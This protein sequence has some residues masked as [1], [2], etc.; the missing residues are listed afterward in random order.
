M[1]H[2]I[3]VFSLLIATAAIIGGVYFSKNPAAYETCLVTARDILKKTFGFAINGVD[4]VKIMTYDEL[5]RYDGSPDG[6]GLYLAVYGKIYDVSKG[7]KHY[8]PGGGY[9]FFSGKDASR[10]YVTGEF[11]EKGLIDDLTGFTPQQAMEVKKWVEFYENTYTFVGKLNGRY[12]DENGNPTPEHA[13]VEDMI[14]EG[15]KLKEVDKA[16]KEKFPT[17]NS[18]W[19]QNEGGKVWCSTKSGGIARDWVGVPRKFFK[20]GS[21]QSRCACIRTTGP[22]SDQPDAKDHANRGDLDNPNI[23]EYE[24]CEPTSVSCALLL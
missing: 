16:E 21:T 24:D 14:A 17:C 7:A 10:A 9:E 2:K 15:I 18:E 12:Y 1:A 20:P 13:K 8:G 11:N 3:L 23:R 4:T 22:P 19:R 6:D 5:K